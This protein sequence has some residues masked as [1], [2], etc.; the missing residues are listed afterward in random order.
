MSADYCIPNSRVEK[1]HL[2]DLVFKFTTFNFLKLFQ[3]LKHETQQYAVLNQLL[4]PKIISDQ[5]CYCT[6][7]NVDDPKISSTCIHN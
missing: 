7:K 2:K 3:H 1:Y 6:A 5:A 4:Y